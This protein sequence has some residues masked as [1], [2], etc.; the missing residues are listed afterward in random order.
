MFYN[1]RQVCLANIIMGPQN[2]PCLAINRYGASIS[3]SLIT[4]WRKEREHFPFS[5]ALSNPQACYAWLRVLTTSH[6]E[7]GQ[8]YTVVSCENRDVI[9]VSTIRTPSSMVYYFPCLFKE[10]SSKFRPPITSHYRNSH[11]I[12]CLEAQCDHPVRPR[13]HWPNKPRNV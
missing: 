4:S 11:M 9:Q 1:D 2:S 3:E 12:W 6:N 13:Y 7:A 5:S 8:L 10:I